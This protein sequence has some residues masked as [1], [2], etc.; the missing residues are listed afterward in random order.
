MNNLANYDPGPGKIPPESGSIMAM[1]DFA[2]DIDAE[3][4]EPSLPSGA[5]LDMP[6]L[7]HIELHRPCCAEVCGTFCCVGLGD[8]GFPCSSGK[9]PRESGSVMAMSEFAGDIDAELGSSSSSSSSLFRKIHHIVYITY[10]Y[11]QYSV[12]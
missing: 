9:I 10:I 12:I 11:K 1:S 4:D 2:D 3:L 6:D 5:H 7:N 8:P